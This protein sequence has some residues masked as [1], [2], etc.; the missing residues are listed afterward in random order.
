MIALPR[1][2]ADLE[3]A[4]WRVDAVSFI[5][6]VLIV[7]I[8]AAVLP[9]AH[10]SLRGDRHGR[11]VTIAIAIMLAATVL[12]SIAGELW[13]LALGWSLATAATLAALGF[14]GG[15]PALV[16]S[17]GW[18]LAG[19]L[20]L[21]S[22]VALDAAAVGGDA[23]PLLLVV[24]ALL[25]S[26]LPPAHPWLVDSLHAPTPVSA[27]LHGG[28]VNGG[29]ILIITQIDRIA[30]SALA[31]AV[32]ATTAS[33][34]IVVGVIAALVRT[35][36][37]GRLVM[38]TVAQMGFMLL[39]A[40]LGLVA[41]AL[42]H[43]V[44]HGFYKSALFL[45]SSDGI[46]RRAAE[47]RAPR[48]FAMSPVAAALRSGAGALLAVTA[49]VVSALAIYPG[50]RGFGELVVLIA[51]SAAFGA[52]GAR[53]TLLVPGTLR[54][55]AAAL[56]GAAAAVVFVIGTSV[57]TATLDLDRPAPSSAATLVVVLATG[58]LLAL[59]ALAAL[60]RWAPASA[61]A[62]TLIAFGHRL[63]AP[64][65]RLRRARSTQPTS[66]PNP[67]ADVDSARRGSSSIGASA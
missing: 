66:Q 8:A 60:R 14:G 46:D 21:W 56:L 2:L 11:A 54:A 4:L 34:A 43:L 52:A 20:A 50:D 16:R 64:V 1:T 27:A 25:R 9:Y 38:S 63:G 17:T 37:K 44:A 18:L 45:S 28:I 26:A 30:P 58:V 12:V 42:L 36:I 32:L 41:A 49:L 31:I 29:G 13:M 67:A 40:A 15:R 35:D 48:A 57:L 51:L 53:L 22:A 59:V 5:L 24:A 61:L 47:R 7:G 3:P 19:D 23:I 6:I 33:V 62:L 65:V 55:V 39:C 10:R